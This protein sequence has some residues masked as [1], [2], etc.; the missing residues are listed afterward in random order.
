MTVRQHFAIAAG[1][2][3]AVFGRAENGRHLVA[4]V[5]GRHG[6]DRQSAIE[7]DRLGESDRGTATQQSASSRWAIFLASRAVSIGT[8][9]TARGKTLAARLPRRSNAPTP[10]MT[11]EDG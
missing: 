4:G 9:I 2:L 1:L 11:R 3:D 10:K 8:C 7:R 5:G 6:E